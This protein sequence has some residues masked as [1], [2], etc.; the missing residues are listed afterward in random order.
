MKVGITQRVERLAEYSEIRDCLDHRWCD[1]LNMLGVTAIPI[2]NTLRNIEGWLHVVNCDA[3]LLT[4]GNDLGCLPNAKNVSLERDQTEIALLKY[5]QS[6]M[7]PVFGVCRGFQLINVFLGGRLERVFGHVANNHSIRSCFDQ[8]NQIITR[9]VNSFHEWG[10]PINNLSSQLI[11]CAY[12]NN[13][14]IESARH[15]RLNWLGIMW[16]PEREREFNATDLELMRKI[17]YKDFK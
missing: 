3:Y 17:F 1:L 13:E 4:G 15:K 14:N 5:A 11:P 12:D 10:I 7:V 9:N 8:D 6:R 2:P 16:H